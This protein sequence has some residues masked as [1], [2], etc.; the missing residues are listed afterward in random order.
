MTKKNSYIE[1]TRFIFIV[2]LLLH[3]TGNYG[4]SENIS[5]MPSGYIVV[6]FFFVLMGAMT[7]AHIDKNKDKIVNPM[8]YGM[9]YTI[10]KIKRLFP[11]AT[12][13]TLICYVWYVINNFDSIGGIKGCFWT[14]TNML[15]EMFFV[16]FSGAFPGTVA[17]FKNAP[18]WFLSA[19]MMVLPLIVYMAVR[20]SDF[21]RNYFAWFAPFLIY[22]W[23]IHSWGNFAVWA[24]YRGFLFG[25]VVRAFADITM[26]C[27]AY[28]VGCKI[29]EFGRGRIWL[30]IA[31]IAGL[32]ATVYSCTVWP[33]TYHLVTVIIIM[34]LCIGISMSG[35]SYTYI[36]N[37][38]VN[39][40]GGLAMPVYCLHWA[41]MTIVGDKLPQATTNTKIMIMVVG[42]IVLAAV[43]QAIVKL[44][45]SKTKKQ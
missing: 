28:L 7:M 20:A 43:M 3:H 17:D 12:A 19:M 14:F 31:E 13:G 6:E 2:V 26:G 5:N 38:V 35:V 37:G 1:L 10:G 24:D 45:S 29:R 23:L 40:L 11:Y 22:G 8:E 41:V 18:L 4:L 32:V 27:A 9:K 25:G 16:T 21:F 36:D 39:Y 42:T 30:T 15:Y 33:D 34:A 44:I